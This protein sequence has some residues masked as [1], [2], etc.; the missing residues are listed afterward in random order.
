[1][2]EKKMKL[3]DLKV[4]SFVTTD[5]GVV[6]GGACLFSESYCGN[7]ETNNCTWSCN[8][9]QTNYSACGTCYGECT[10]TGGCSASGW[11]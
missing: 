7:G 6:T 3:E 5:P 10:G 8:S 4:Q 11:C 1:M 2:K 9:F